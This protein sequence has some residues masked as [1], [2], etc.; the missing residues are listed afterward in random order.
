MRAWAVF[1]LVL[2]ILGPF[3]AEAVRIKDIAGIEGV[4]TNQLI[5]YGL[6]IGLKGTGDKKDNLFTQRTLEE[7]LFRLGISV[8]ARDVEVENVASVVVTATLPPFA[9]PGQR[10][11][12]LVSSLADAESLQGGTLLLTPLRGADGQ[13]Y[14]VAQGAVSLGG[15]S[16]QGGG[17]SRQTNHPTVGQLPS[18][19]IVER[20][21]PTLFA[22]K[23][24]YTISLNHPDFTT[25]SRVAE[26]VN[27]AF[28]EATA[29][30]ANAGSVTVTLPQAHQADPVGFF[31]ALERLEV[32]PDSVAKVVLDERTGTIVMGENV[33]ISTVAISHGSLSI[34]I[35]EAPEVSQPAPL[36]EGETVVVPRT[37]IGI[38]EKEARLLLLSQG[39]TIGDLVKG[40]NA[41]GATPRDFIAIFQALKAAGALHAVLEIM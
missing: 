31:A 23:D 14:A 40:L 2:P 10:I 16:A 32:V 17:A 4:R 20:E 24:V 7:M 1:L 5:G 12:V 26:A 35:K 29:H 38:R 3:R 30:P 22:Q 21:V 18:G 27:R 13:V 37:Q 8:S 9:K 6:V 25:A 34:Q 33:R 15:F 41:V 11:D 36:G 28:G 39:A 19:A